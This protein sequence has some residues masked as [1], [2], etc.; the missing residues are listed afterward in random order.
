MW[1]S[2]EPSGC[3]AQAPSREVAVSAGVF[4]VDGPTDTIPYTVAPAAGA[5]EQ[6]QG[7]D[8][9]EQDT[10]SAISMHGFKRRIGSSLGRQG[11]DTYIA[12]AP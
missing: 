1:L 10:A 5:G 4:V 9:A 12:S 6:A 2:D 7:A 11:T 8:T 3:D